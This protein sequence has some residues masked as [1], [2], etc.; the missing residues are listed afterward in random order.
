MAGRQYFTG[1]AFA[2]D[3][4]GHLNIVPDTIR[5]RNV[6]TFRTGFSA[7]ES[8]RSVPLK[9][10]PPSATMSLGQEPDVAANGY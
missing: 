1:A 2:D 7:S 9:R 6:S 4:H 5:Y 3:G 10:G 8:D